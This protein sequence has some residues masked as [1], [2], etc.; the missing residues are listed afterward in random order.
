MKLIREHLYEKFSEA[1]DPIRDLDIG[2][3]SRRVFTTTENAVNFF[4]KH[5]SN[6]LETENIPED[7]INNKKNYYMPSKYFNKLR[8]YFLKY[9]KVESE[10]DN[11]FGFESFLEYVI[12]KLVQLGYKKE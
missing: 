7:I 9:I 4:I 11:F 5:I 8:D 1:S 2:L 6:I 12:P 3:Y 10:K